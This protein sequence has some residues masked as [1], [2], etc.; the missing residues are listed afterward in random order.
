MF[1]CIA[2]VAVSIVFRIVFNFKVQG[3]EYLTAYKNNG[4]P[5]VVCGNHLSMIDPVFVVMAYGVG[6]KMSIMG[7]AE[8]FRV[9]VLKTL[10]KWVG[11][12]PVERGTADNSALE[13]GIEDVKSGRGMMIFPEG[14]RGDRDEMQKV[15][16]GAF[17]V[18]RATGADIVPVRLIFPN[19]NCKPRLF[20]KVVVKFG[21]PIKAEDM[22]LSSEDKRSLRV[23]R[24][25]Y[26]ESMENILRRYCRETGYVP[27]MREIEKEK[28]SPVEE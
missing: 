21:E 7:K 16:S 25:K 14:T 9:P 24:I 26:K 27:K 22:N 1:Y 3:R 4:R 12:F 28:I 8:L 17:V 19:T 23:R 2:F 20:G 15:K 18:A 5:F 13:K 6:K 11:C 10:L